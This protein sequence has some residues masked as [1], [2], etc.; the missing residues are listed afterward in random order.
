MA[1]LSTEEALLQTLAELQA[2]G[3]YAGFAGPGLALRHVKDYYGLDWPDV[4][5]GARTPAGLDQ[6]LLW[7]DERR[8]WCRDLE[9]VYPGEEAY[10]T[11]LREWAGISRGLFEP[12]EVLERWH[13][14]LGPVE[15]TWK[16]AGRAFRLDHPDGHDDFL[17]HLALMRQ[18]NQGLRDP[19]YRFVACDDYPGDCRFVVVLHEREQRLLRG[20]G[21]S[22]C[23]LP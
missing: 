12:Q 10:A 7:P 23:A 6:L 14:P 18:V 16:A 5:A 4:L 11:T 19:A 2:L 20:R 3:F 8:V 13:T 15:V 17:H 21:W 9:G 22:F 1:A